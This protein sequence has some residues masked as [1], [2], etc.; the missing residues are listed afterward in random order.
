MEVDSQGFTGTYN[1]LAFS[2]SGFPAIAYW[3]ASNQDLKFAEFDGTMWNISTVDFDGFTGLDP[4][5]A[6][7]PDGKPAISYWDE[8]AKDLNYPFL[9]GPPGTSNRSIQTVLLGSIPLWSLL[10]AGSPRSVT[11]TPARGR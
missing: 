4:S 6:Y 10:P 8:T 9:T 1:S 2:P 7:T 5:L 11:L 3:Q